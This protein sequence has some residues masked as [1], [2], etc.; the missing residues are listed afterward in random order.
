[1]PMGAGPGP[2]VLP[3][4]AGMGTALQ[5]LRALYGRFPLP[6]IR[7]LIEEAMEQQQGQQ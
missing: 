1:M 3:A 7:D 4:P 2:D 5:E 6:E